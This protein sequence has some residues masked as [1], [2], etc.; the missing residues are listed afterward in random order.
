MC[1]MRVVVWLMYVSYSFARVGAGL[2]R[3]SSRQMDVQRDSSGVRTSV[4]AAEH[5][6]GDLHGQ[7]K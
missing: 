3:G 1:W 7:Q 2:L 6:A 5:G 4:S